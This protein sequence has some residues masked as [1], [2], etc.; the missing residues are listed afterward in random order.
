MIEDWR[1]KV[2]T[3]FN[4]KES[5]DTSTN[6]NDVSKR[7]NKRCISNEGTSSK[8]NTPRMQDERISINV[9]APQKW[10]RESLHDSLID[11]RARAW[12]SPTQPDHTLSWQK[13]KDEKGP[14]VTGAGRT[15]YCT[16]TRVGIVD[17][18]TN[19]AIDIN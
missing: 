18:P 13:R 12:P 4:Y 3:L 10:H 11:R 19:V 8:G 5:F 17:S 9:F 2:C 14:P 16:D 7:G 15:A 6:G 1:L